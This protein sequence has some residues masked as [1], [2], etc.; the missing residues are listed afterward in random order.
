MKLPLPLMARFRAF[1]AKM[2]AA[3][4]GKWTDPAVVEYLLDLAHQED[5]APKRARPKPSR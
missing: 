5:G 4:G 1:A 3:R 2:A